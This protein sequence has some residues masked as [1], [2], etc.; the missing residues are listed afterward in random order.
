MDQET[1]LKH[2]A[3]AES[4]FLHIEQ[5]SW[6]SAHR[7]SQGLA[8]ALYDYI[9]HHVIETAKNHLHELKAQRIAPAVGEKK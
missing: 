6:G 3:M 1:K 8:D 7:A 4:I 2:L 9:D 5:E